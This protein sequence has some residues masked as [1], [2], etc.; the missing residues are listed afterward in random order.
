MKNSGTFVGRSERCK[1]QPK[2]PEQ[3]IPESRLNTK[4]EANWHLDFNSVFLP[5]SAKM[6]YVDRFIKI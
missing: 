5:I 2:M 1:F 3:I 6:Q 4:E